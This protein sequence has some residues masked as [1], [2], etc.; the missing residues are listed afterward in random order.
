MCPHICIQFLVLLTNFCHRRGKKGLFTTIFPNKIDMG[1]CLSLPIK[2]RIYLPLS[3]IFVISIGYCLQCLDG[4]LNKTIS[5]LPKSLKSKPLQYRDRR[6]EE[7]IFL[8][9]RPSPPAPLTTTCLIPWTDALLSTEHFRFHYL[10]FNG[11]GKLCLYPRHS[12][13]QKSQSSF[14]FH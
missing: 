1:F 3:T 12:Y 7:P 6:I 14:S 10:Y 11:I 2:M 5:P 9:S 13:S 4:R 8:Y